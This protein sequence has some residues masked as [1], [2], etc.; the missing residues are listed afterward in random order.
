M[1]LHIKTTGLCLIV[2]EPSGDP[3]RYHLL[4]PQST[5]HHPHKAILN[6][7][8]AADEY[9]LALCSLDLTAITAIPGAADLRN[10]IDVEALVDAKVPLRQLGNSPD[11]TVSARIT[12]P[13][14]TWTAPGETAPWQPVRPN[15]TPIAV[16]PSTHHM[17]WVYENFDPSS[18]MLRRQMLHPGGTTDTSL[19]P[20]PKPHGNVVCI[21]ITHLPPPGNVVD[22]GHASPHFHMYGHI[23]DPPKA[24][25]MKLKRKPT[26]LPEPYECDGS[27]K[28]REPR[29]EIAYNCMLGKSGAG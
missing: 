16:F 25:A 2:P 21:S 3:D 20:A 4:L 24:P 27:S 23:Y 22:V 12:L 18:L 8:G 13:V 19:L 11:N 10:I 28:A 29:S 5:P 14:P 1:D 17:T 6:Y 26:K 7:V 9:D 15:G